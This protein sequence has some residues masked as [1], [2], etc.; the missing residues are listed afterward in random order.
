MVLLSWLESLPKSDTE[1][2]EHHGPPS[3]GASHND[4]N[5]N[6]INRRNQ[7]LTRT[8]PYR[9][10]VLTNGSF[11][12]LKDIP[13]GSDEGSTRLTTSTV[14]DSNS[15]D[16]SSGSSYNNVGLTSKSIKDPSLATGTVPGQPNIKRSNTSAAQLAKTETM[17]QAGLRRSHNTGYYSFRDYS[18]V[19]GTATLGRGGAAYKNNLSVLA[20]DEMPGGTMRNNR[21]RTKRTESFV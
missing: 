10:K 8:N 20:E 9:H 11:V 18:P 5:I 13:T 2:L 7:T 19:Y 4:S 3:P 14:D 1:S 12:S 6:T 17:S 15:S 16:T 21:Q